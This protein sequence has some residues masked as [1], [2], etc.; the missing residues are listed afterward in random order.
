MVFKVR[1]PRVDANVTEAAV[2]QWLV[3]C[4]ERVAVGQPLVELITD[5]AAFELPSEHDGVIGRRIAS[6]KDVLPVGYVIALIADAPDEPLPDV[7]DEND[8]VMAA[9]QEVLIYGGAPVP[10]AE[11]APV[12]SPAAQAAPEPGRLRV[13]P[14]VRRLA[15]QHGIDLAGLA[16]RT[17]G[18]VGMADVERE[19]ARRGKGQ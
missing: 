19:I 17:G 16:E 10:E 14:R 2:G 12:S 6:E 5:K 8:A 7:S 11:P 15:A 3:E 9:Y 18:R 13:P 4:G 1:V